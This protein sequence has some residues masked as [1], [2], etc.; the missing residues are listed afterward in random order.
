[1]DDE[2]KAQAQEQMEFARSTAQ[3]MEDAGIDLKNA[4]I[5]I[6]ETSVE[7]LQH[8]GPPGSV[9]GLIGEQLQLKLAVKT[10]GKSKSGTPLSGEYILAASQIM[11]FSNDWKIV[12]N[13][14]WSQLPAGVLDGKAAAKMDFEN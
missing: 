8:P 2:L 4:D 6:M 5:Q 1:M 3:Q 9:S 11:R 14:H 10:K 7:R 12:A 13:L